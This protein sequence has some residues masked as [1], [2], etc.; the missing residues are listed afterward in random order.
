MV[1][2]AAQY[3]DDETILAKLP[4]VTVDEVE[5]ILKKKDAEDETRYVSEQEQ[6]QEEEEVTN[7]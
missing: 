5:E 2:S 4:F 6:P 7:E 1:L 3:L